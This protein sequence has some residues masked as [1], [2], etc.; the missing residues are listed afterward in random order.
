MPSVADD[1]GDPSQ[2]RLA[3][4]AYFVCMRIDADRWL[5]KVQALSAILSRLSRASWW[6]CAADKLYHMYA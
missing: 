3:V 5:Y 2:V 1:V 6:P 4:G